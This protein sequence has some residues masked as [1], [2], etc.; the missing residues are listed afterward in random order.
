MSRL[1]R[2]VLS[3]F[4]FLTVKL[5]PRRRS[6]DEVQFAL[7]AQCLS[8]VYARKRFL[9]T[10]WVFLPDHWHAIQFPPFPLTVSAAMKSVKLSSTNLL[11]RFRDE[12]GAGSAD[13]AL[14]EVCGFFSRIT[15]YRRVSGK[16]NS[17]LLTSTSSG[18]VSIAHCVR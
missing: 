12:A 2:L 17:A 3:D 9:L 10:A 16:R 18:Q 6:L 13:F 1:R 11:G 4:F 8:V 7:L 14:L 15:K 5:L